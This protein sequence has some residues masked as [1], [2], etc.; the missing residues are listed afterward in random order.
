MSTS[1]TPSGQPTGRQSPYTPEEASQKYE[2]VKEG[3]VDE[4][5]RAPK[6]GT[7]EGYSSGLHGQPGEHDE[8]F[9]TNSDA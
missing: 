5:E 1:S 9:K 7:G 8:T 6:T 2:Y 3:T 4:G